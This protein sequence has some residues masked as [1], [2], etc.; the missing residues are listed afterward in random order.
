MTCPTSESIT[1]VNQ[2]T[3]ND[4]NPNNS[5]SLQDQILDHVSLLKSL[6]KKHNERPETLIEPIHLSFGDEDGSDKRKGVDK[7]SKDAEDEDLQK[8]Y[9]EIL[10]FMGATNQE[11]WQIPVWCRMHQK[12]L[13]GS[14]RG[15]FDHLPN[16]CI[17]NWADLLEKITE[18]FALRRRCFK[19]P[20]EVSKIIQ[21]DNETLAD[22]KERWMDEMSYIQDVLENKR[23]RGLDERTNNLPPIPA[24]DVLDESL[25]VESEVEGLTEIRDLRD[26]S[27]TIHA[28]MKF[29]TL[30]GIA[31][32]VAQTASVFKCRR[33]EEKRTVQEEKDKE[34]KPKRQENPKGGSPRQP[35]I[36]GTESHDQDAVLQRMPT[37]I[38]K[39]SKGQHGPQKRRV[40]GTKKSMTVMKEVEEWV[41]VGIMYT[42]DTIKSRCLKKMRRRMPCI[43]I[44]GPIVTLR[45]RSSLKTLVPHTIEDQYEVKPEEMFIHRRGWKALG[46]YVTDQPIKQIINKLEIFEKLAKYAVGLGAYYITYIPLNAVKGQVLVDFLNE[47]PIATKHMEICSLT[48][49]EANLE[50]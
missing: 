19:D 46:L 2:V 36:L 41:K 29:P 13:G 31:T 23:R 22:F 49:E 38:D 26:V 37:S 25:I 48:G 44:N 20:I 17:D 30:R 35:N 50:E 9:K 18:M 7:G 24:N 15:W 1:P 11:E 3:R 33:L 47:T 12:M 8:P 40:L 39:P 27:S 32:L 42:K 21:R 5:P 16:G 28:M 43:L 6:I 45:C 10:S 14:I 34:K 4:D